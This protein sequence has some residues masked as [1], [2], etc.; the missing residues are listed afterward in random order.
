MVDFKHRDLMTTNSDPD[1]AK[2]VSIASR[3]ARPEGGYEAD[4]D[5]SSTAQAALPAGFLNRVDDTIVFPQ[6]LRQ[7]S[8]SST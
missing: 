1:I 5:K 4:E 2:G 6:C 7:S 8:R 3:P